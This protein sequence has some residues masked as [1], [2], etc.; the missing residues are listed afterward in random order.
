MINLCVFTFLNMLIASILPAQVI[1]SSLPLGTISFSV[2]PEVFQVGTNFLA[3]CEV[4]IEPKINDWRYRVTYSLNNI[5]LA[6]Y[7]VNGLQAVPLWKP[8]N[9]LTGVN[10][11]PE[12][13]SQYPFFYAEVQPLSADA[14]GT[15][16]CAVKS[17]FIPTFPSSRSIYYSNKWSTYSS[18]QTF[19][20]YATVKY[21]ISKYSEDDSS[22]RS[23]TYT[24]ECSLSMSPNTGNYN[25]TFRMGR[26]PLGEFVVKRMY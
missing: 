25:V 8:L 18:M 17:E 5:E 21:T 20:P 6:E 15:W 23:V 3:K 2:Y 13:R 24:G 4:N 26:L 11:Y 16:Q 1:T 12:S 22:S 10:I 19:I 14:H 9:L 7:E